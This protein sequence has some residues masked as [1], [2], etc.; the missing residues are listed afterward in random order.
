[1]DEQSKSK[2]TGHRP[3]PENVE[4]VGLYSIFV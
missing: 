3:K 4:I 1:M 2:I